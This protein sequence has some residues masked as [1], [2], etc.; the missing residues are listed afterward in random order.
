MGVQRY[1]LFLCKQ[2]N[3]IFF[4]SHKA[5]YVNILGK[6]NVGKSTLMNVLVGEKLSV[7]TNKAQTT[8][9][10]IL[11]IL[12]DEDYQ[13]VFSDTP[14][15]VDPHYKL[16]QAMM[17]EVRSAFEDAD[18]VL[19]V[20]E[21]GENKAD[22]KL[23]SFIEK[24]N[25]PVIVALNKI[26]NGSQEE[27]QAAIGNWKKIIPSASVLPVAALHNFNV[28][29]L[30]S[31]IIEVLPEHPAFYPKDELTDK[32]YRFF[33]SEIIREKILLLYRKEVPYSVEVIVDSFKE[34]EDIVRIAAFIY[35]ARE[36]QKMI[37]IGKD[38]RAI[39]R[40]G[41]DARKD[42]EK[43]LNKKVY[44]ELS[45]KVEKDWRDKEQSLKR[46]GYK[47]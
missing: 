31:M 42:I 6:P 3:Y 45:V 21:F 37:V 17:S 19:Y 25:I 30:L 4:M 32:N 7:I 18:V 5:G 44:L 10:R 8:R 14:G 15:I 12:S 43:F 39:K 24:K 16:H 35:V 40:L 28:D 36:S 1:N 47:T 27:V 33:V 34:T 11:G 13:I 46:F 38:G 2:E 41:T 22:D 26:D 23:V 9:H 29:Q 20:V